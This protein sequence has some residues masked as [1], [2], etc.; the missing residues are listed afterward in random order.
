MRTMRNF[1][2]NENGKAPRGLT[3]H[4]AYNW[5]NAYHGPGFADK[6]FRALQVGSVRSVPVSK[7]TL[8]YGRT[9][10]KMTQ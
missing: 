3:N 9:D 5:L 2:F 1:V 6:L 7:G 4:T 10:G 8:T